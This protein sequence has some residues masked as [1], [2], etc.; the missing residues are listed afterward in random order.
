MNI[1][2]Y[3]KGIESGCTQDRIHNKLFLLIIDQFQRY[4]HQ[5]GRYS[6]RST[7]RVVMNFSKNLF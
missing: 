1:C 5:C 4:Y 2:A 3:F 7:E 6:Q